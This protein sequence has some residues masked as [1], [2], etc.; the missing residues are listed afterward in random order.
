MTSIMGAHRKY[1]TSSNA[2][3]TGT[4]AGIKRLTH[5]KNARL[6]DPCIFR[7]QGQLKARA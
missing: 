6:S 2:I 5:N 7:R 1:I 4:N 3:K